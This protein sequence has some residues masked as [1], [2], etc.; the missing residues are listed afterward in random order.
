L[1]TVLLG[2]PTPPSLC[3]TS[4]DHVSIKRGENA[5]LTQSE[6]QEKRPL[7]TSL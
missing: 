2:I 5:S 7:Q 6:T 4:D 3:A 1:I